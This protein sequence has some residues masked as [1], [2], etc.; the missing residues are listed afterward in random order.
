M[1][2]VDLYRYDDAWE[3][4]ATHALNTY[5]TLLPVGSQDIMAALATGG[6]REL[7]KIFIPQPNTQIL[8]FRRSDDYDAFHLPKSVNIP[9][10][11]LREGAVRGS[12]FADPVGDCSMLEELWLELES[13]FTVTDGAGKKNPSADAL[14]AIL[15]GK[16][17]LTLCYDGDSSRVANSVLRAKGVN[18]ESILG[19]YT[20]L[21]NVRLPRIETSKTAA[22]AVSVE[23]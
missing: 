5:F 22:L 14:M 6:P 3:L 20:A 21:A 12:P 2:N 18:S 8:D 10:E 9:L 16:N 23:A 7:E 1:R 19:G 11:T 4:D 13:L 17:V 15:R